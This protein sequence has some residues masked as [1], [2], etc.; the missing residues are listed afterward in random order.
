MLPV[1]KALVLATRVSGI[2]FA[3]GGL[4]SISGVVIDPSGAAVPAA[5]VVLLE[6][7]ASINEIGLFTL[8]SVLPGRYTGT[9]TAQGFRGK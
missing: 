7:S 5:A 4:G 1:P 6:I 2:A 9:L 3:Q 8:P